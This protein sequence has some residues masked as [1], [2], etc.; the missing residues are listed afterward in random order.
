MLQE[1]L[2]SHLKE[3]LSEVGHKVSNGCGRTSPSPSPAE[4]AQNGS[5]VDVK[6]EPMETGEAEIEPG[7]S[8][9]EQTNGHQGNEDGP[10]GSRD[11]EI[12]EMDN[13][14]D[15]KP[16]IDSIAGPSCSNST[17]VLDK[18]DTQACSSSSEGGNLLLKLLQYDL[19]KKN[20][21]LLVLPG[22]Y[23]HIDPKEKGPY[24]KLG[25]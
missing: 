1:Q 3:L 11:N 4:D 24:Q 22:K 25:G 10:S 19:R 23:I 8:L 20:H 21:N 2:I 9:S 5:V 14:T 6:E 7:N 16:S 15:S 13:S 12:T 18:D 17:V